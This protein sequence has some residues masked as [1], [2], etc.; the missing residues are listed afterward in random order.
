MC[1]NVL[2]KLARVLLA[3]PSFG[4][5]LNGSAN[6]L[7]E[8]LHCGGE[9]KGAFSLVY[10]FL[11]AANATTVWESWFASSNTYSHNHPM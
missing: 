7:G 2:G 5:M 8:L 3:D 6:G 4:Y 9:E 11:R 1:D 10:P